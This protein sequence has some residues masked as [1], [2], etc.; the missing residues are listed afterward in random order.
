MEEINQWSTF[1]YDEPRKK[2][3]GRHERDGGHW[4]E[5]AE[6]LYSKCKWLKWSTNYLLRDNYILNSIIL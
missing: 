5:G 4:G 1:S 6:G 2:L 3:R